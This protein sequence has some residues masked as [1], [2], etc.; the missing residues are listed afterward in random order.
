MQATLYVYIIIYGFYPHKH[1]LVSVKAYNNIYLI[2]TDL[3]LSLT[4]TPPLDELVETGPMIQATTKRF[5]A[6]QGFYVYLQHMYLC[7]RCK[8][9]LPPTP[10]AAPSCRAKALSKPILSCEGGLGP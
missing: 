9:K 5:L 8:T 3:F 2:D 6:P 1:F 10:G 4:K 7:R